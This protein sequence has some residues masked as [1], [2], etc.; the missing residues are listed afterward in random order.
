[1]ETKKNFDAVKWVREIRDKFYEEHKHLKGRDYIDAIKNE[2]RVKGKKK[3]LRTTKKK[4][5]A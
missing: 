5:L 1:M 3:R 4:N 2:I